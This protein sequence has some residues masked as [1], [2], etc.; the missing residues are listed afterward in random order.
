M[1]DD[2]A[3][4]PLT[5]RLVWTVPTGFLCLLLPARAGVAVDHGNGATGAGIAFALFALP[6]LYTLPS[7]RAVWDRHRWWLLSAQAVLTY[8]PFLIYG[9]TWVL[10]L[11]GLL[12]GLVLLAVRAPVSWLLFGAILAIEGA[13]R[14]GVYGA[15]PATGAQ[16]YSWVFVV[17]IGMALPLFGLVR[18]S[19]LVVDLRAARTELAGLA[20]TRERLQSAG[21]LRAAIGDRLEAVTVRAVAALRELP[22]NLDPARAHL[23]DAG[24]LARQAAQQVR[25]TVTDPEP[26]PE[27]VPPARWRTGRTVAPRLAMLVLVVDLGAYAIHHV[28]I[29]FDSSSSRALTA[30]A[31]VAVGAIVALQLYHSLA[32]RPGGGP[33]GWPVTLPVQALLPFT[34]FVNASLL[35]LPA[36]PAGSALLLLRG[37][38]AGAAFAVISS[39][40]AAYW[41]VLQ[42]GDVDGVVYLVGLTTST[43]LAVY[44]LSRLR[45]L[46]EEQETIGRDL[47]RAA[48]E[49]ERRRVGQ[50]THDLLGLG[51]SAIALKCDLAGRLIGRDDTRAQ[52]E[53]HKLLRLAA[54][55]R[56]DIRAVTA[57]EPGLSIRT[58]LVAARDVLGTAGVRVEVTTTGAESVPADVDAVLATV[59][60]EAVTNV[61]RHSRATR[62]DIDLRANAVTVSLRIA[63]DGAGA[64]PAAPPAPT[65]GR[66]VG[67]RGLAN[68]AARVQARGGQLKTNVE[69]GRFELTA[70]LALPADG[71]GRE[72]G[73]DP[74]AAGGAAHGADEVVG[75]AVLDQEP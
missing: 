38:L 74:L 6:L 67:G 75:G 70:R 9:Q 49:R 18:L 41:L 21:R 60:R 5:P 55:A 50:D 37:W 52:M 72:G 34:E 31:V 56:A 4:G 62:C 69:D 14:I 71:S 40:M 48:V 17:P 29:V 11:S 25:Q 42:P 64:A 54:Q 47:A 2:G 12:G 35:G 66:P 36:F 59:L 22:L 39:S 13:I 24:G 63:N 45:D 58:E 51:L 16:S 8:V 32:G 10:G 15:Y 33:R 61:L 20:V 30:V 46:A 68:L 44:G 3:H 27:R 26:E 23:A 7:G 57:G 28:M 43:G 73:V 19:D 1:A 65:H 53:L